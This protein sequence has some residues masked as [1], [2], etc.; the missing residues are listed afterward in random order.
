MQVAKDSIDDCFY[1]IKELDLLCRSPYKKVWYSAVFKS[2]RFMY[3]ELADPS[4]KI[5]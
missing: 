3:R 2:A 1:I 5:K 4:Q